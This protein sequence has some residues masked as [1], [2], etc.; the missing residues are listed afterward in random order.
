MY[1]SVRWSIDFGAFLGTILHK[2]SF[3]TI[4]NI[5]LFKGQAGDSL[6]MAQVGRMTME[7]NLEVLEY[8][9]LFT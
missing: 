2:W 7:I 6:K 9:K 1:S 3:P 5:P 8:K 4:Q